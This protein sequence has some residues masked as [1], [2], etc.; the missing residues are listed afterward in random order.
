MKKT[1]ITP[2]NAGGVKLKPPPPSKPFRLEYEEAKQEIF[3]AVIRSAK[4]H[5]I[6]YFLLDGIITEILYQ[7]K[8]GARDEKL[9]AEHIYRT[10][11]DE[12]EK[13]KQEE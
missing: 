13:S 6:P 1:K 11:L 4:T 8:D 12:Y 7:V 10:Q 9:T 3:S 5:N 2:P